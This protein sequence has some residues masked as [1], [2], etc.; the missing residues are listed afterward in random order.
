M[1][2]YKNDKDNPNS[3][4]LKQ[5]TSFTAH[6]TCSYDDL[7]LECQLLG[8][9]TNYTKKDKQNIIKYLCNLIS[10]LSCHLQQYFLIKTSYLFQHK[11]QLPYVQNFQIKHEH[12]K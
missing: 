12:I 10:P 7:Y 8:I 4:A 3:V 2:D 6:F 5:S 1:Y 11:N 9:S